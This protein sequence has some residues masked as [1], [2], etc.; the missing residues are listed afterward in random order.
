[1]TVCSIAGS[2]GDAEINRHIQDLAVYI[3]NLFLLTS[4]AVAPIIKDNQLTQEVAGNVDT[5]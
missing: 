3:S 4:D 2:G 5:A 1:M